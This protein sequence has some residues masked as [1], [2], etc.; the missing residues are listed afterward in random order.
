M[1]RVLKWVGIIFLSILILLA[2]L[3]IGLA[4]S[5]E[6]KRFACVGEVSS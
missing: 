6:E 3:F 5:K 1:M 4:N 2:L